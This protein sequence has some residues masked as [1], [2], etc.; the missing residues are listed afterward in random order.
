MELQPP[1]ARD[2]A[3]LRDTHECPCDDID[4]RAGHVNRYDMLSY[5]NER[6]AF[7][8]HRARRL[9][10]ARRFDACA[11]PAP[12]DML[13]RS[14]HISLLYIYLY[15]PHFAPRRILTSS[16]STLQPPHAT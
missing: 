10:T 11:L 4:Q 3:M 8:R 15:L 12:E 14:S 1:D 2:A 16:L 9:F 5:L 6:S 7:P 13:Y